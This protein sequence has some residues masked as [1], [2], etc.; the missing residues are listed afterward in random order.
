[1]IDNITVDTGKS[2]QTIHLGDKIVVTD[3]INNK[4]YE[5]VISIEVYEEGYC[6]IET[7]KRRR[8]YNNDRIISYEQ[9]R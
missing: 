3:N 8:Y 9:I 7:V 2:T 5:E 1:M 4:T 6:L